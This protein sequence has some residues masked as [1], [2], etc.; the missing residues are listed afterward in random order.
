MKKY[1]GLLNTLAFFKG[2][3]KT[4]IEAVLGCLGSR[5][6]TV[7]KDEILLHAGNKPKHLGI[8]LDGLLHITR[9]DYD[10][11]RTLIAVVSSG[12]IYGE[13]LCCSGISESPVTVSAAANSLVLLLGFPRVL[14][15]CSNSCVFH[16]KLIENMLGIIAN[17]N[18]FLQARMEIVS[19][20]SVRAK[21]LQFFESFSP[22]NGHEFFIPLNREE[23][24]D[25]LCV[26]R[27]ALSHE[28]S[29]MKKEGLIE[30]KKNKFTM[31]LGS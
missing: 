31:F 19:L 5:I 14:Q 25:Y 4:D 28:L 1:F 22:K 18:L 10:G 23:M 2:I 13:A 7:K 12:E 30:Y 3:S 26:E 11:N 15:T 29:R 20:K 24:A 9:D 27:S 16:T 8:V 6:K 17:K 21:V